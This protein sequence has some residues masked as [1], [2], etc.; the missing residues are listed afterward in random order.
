MKKMTESITLNE[1]HYLSA[2]EKYNS[3]WEAAKGELEGINQSI[4]HNEESRLSFFKKTVCNAIK[5]FEEFNSFDIDVKKIDE[6]AK[7]GD[8]E[9]TEDSF[10]KKLKQKI[11]RLVKN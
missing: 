7:R 5:T 2:V 10:Q 1:K 8:G 6:T 3:E 4:A 11:D 9:K